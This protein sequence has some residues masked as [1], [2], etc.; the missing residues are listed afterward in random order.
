MLTNSLNVNSHSIKDEYTSK[1]VDDV[2][3]IVE[4]DEL[5]TTDIP[6]L[7]KQAES[8][9]A[10]TELKVKNQK[11][12]KKVRNIY[13]TDKYI[14]PYFTRSGRA[15]KMPG[16]FDP[17]AM[18][19]WRVLTVTER[20][21]KPTITMNKR[22]RREDARWIES[23]KREVDKLISAGVMVKLPRDEYGRYILPENYIKM[24]LIDLHEYKWKSHPVTGEECWLECTRIVCDGSC[25]TREDEFTYAEC[26]D[27][28]ILHV[29]TSIDS[30]EKAWVYQADIQRAYLQ[31][32]SLDRNLVVI[33]SSIPAFGE[34]LM[35][36]DKGLY[37]AKKSALSFQV[38]TDEKLV[39]LKY[40]KMNIAKSIYIKR[41]NDRVIRIYRHSDDFRISCTNLEVLQAEI[42][43]LEV[44][45]DFGEKGFTLLERFLGCEYE[46]I[47]Q[48]GNP[49]PNGQITL[50]R[51]AEKIDSMADQYSD[52]R[53]MFKISNTHQYT[54]L[55]TDP[56]RDD[57]KLDEEMRKPLTVQLV[58]RYMSIVGSIGYVACSVRMAIRF[59]HFVLARRL[60]NPR[61]WD[62]YMSVWVLEYL[63]A[64]RDMPLVLGGDTYS[65]RVRC[66]A[67]L[68][69]LP[70]RRSVGAHVLTT[71][72][73]SGACYVMCSVIKSVVVSIF[74]AELN[75]YV[76]GLDTMLYVMHACDEMLYVRTD[77]NYAL[78]DSES[79]LNWIE[80]GIASR[81]SR[82]VELRLHRARQIILGGEI[83]A[84][85]VD[86]K[87]N[88]SD[89]FTKHLDM[90]QSQYL[91][92]TTMGHALVS[93]LKVAGVRVKF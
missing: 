45:F 90:K 48:Q 25:D 42:I 84:G 76:D 4:D 7:T 62:L 23:D 65:L 17:T 6:T 2:D 80:S 88:I 93:H 14:E 89:L 9:N 24:R 58:R 53:D 47:D 30:V 78:T 39:K 60:Q 13:H 83:T 64:T 91:T 26:P 12:S 36:L 66:D 22:K 71:S 21:P 67:S 29:M 35:L 20:P 37:G 55:P 85:H 40:V 3:K 38:W 92:F 52:L 34:A 77:D 44:E 10:S 1:Q 19:M 28:T 69:S 43:V 72:M 31:A 61:R 54:H 70:D 18:M 87:D 15:K 46:R 33:T 41:V 79:T 63:I 16:K 59:A 50:V 56:L 81:K 82:H 11:T 32:T 68:G 86:T 8:N 73:R 74:E 27:R 5:I 57:D 49:C 51:C 75:A